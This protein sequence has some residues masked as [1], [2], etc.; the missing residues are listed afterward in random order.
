[1]NQGRTYEKTGTAIMALTASGAIGG[2]AVASLPVPTYI[3]QPP[4]PELGLHAGATHDRVALGAEWSV[5]LV[6]LVVGIIRVAHRI[7][8]L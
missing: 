4:A 2:P 6:F 7:L 8:R 1:M 5:V 3:A